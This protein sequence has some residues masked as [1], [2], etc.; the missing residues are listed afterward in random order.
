MDSLM[1][2]PGFFG[3]H[4][5]LGS[6]LSLLV[7]IVSAVVFTAGWRL[8]VRERF[9]AHRWVM[10]AAVALNPIPVAIW[11]IRYFVLY[12]M[13]SFRPDWGKARMLSRLC[14]P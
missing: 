5:P 12:T 13:R 2:S 10:S 6:D 4:A 11:M 7:T 14:M 3:N 9:E 8:A 1:N